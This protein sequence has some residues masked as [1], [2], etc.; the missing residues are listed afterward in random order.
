[1]P[2]D[3]ELH[4]LGNSERTF[5]PVTLMQLARAVSQVESCEH[6]SPE[7][8]IPFHWILRR[9]TG[10]QDYADYILPAPGRC[11]NCRSDIHEKTLVQPK[12][13]AGLP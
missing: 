2:D 4:D 6:C 12:N 10:A 1:M 5:V 13:E 9:L 11:P 8:Q 7:A 3:D